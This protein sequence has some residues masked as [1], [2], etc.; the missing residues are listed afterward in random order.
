MFVLIFYD[1]MHADIHTIDCLYN[2]SL[3]FR[4]KSSFNLYPQKRRFVSFMEVLIRT[5]V[6]HYVLTRTHRCISFNIFLP[7]L[8]VIGHRSIMIEGVD[9]VCCNEEGEAGVLRLREK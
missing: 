4:C 6:E 9:W 2:A 3:I 1:N 8:S 7:H 5:P